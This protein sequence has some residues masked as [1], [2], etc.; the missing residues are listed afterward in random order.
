MM[1]TVWMGSWTP[2][3]VVVLFNAT[4]IYQSIPFEIQSTSSYF[5]YYK[6]LSADSK[7]MKYKVNSGFVRPEGLKAPANETGI[8]FMLFFKVRGKLFVITSYT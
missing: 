1:L 5:S 4:G 3:T 6:H 7:T 2:Y 8:K